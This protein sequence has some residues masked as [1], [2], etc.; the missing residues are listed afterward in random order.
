MRFRNILSAVRVYVEPDEDEVFGDASPGFA[1]KAAPLLVNDV[2]RLLTSVSTIFEYRHIVAHE[3]N[4]SIISVQKLGEYIECAKVFTEA[5]YELVDQI[6]NPGVSRTGYY[7]S[8]QEL[9]KAG[10]IRLE[11]QI[12][13]DE[14]ASRL[15]SAKEERPEAIGLFEECCKT[16]DLYENAE[17][18]F[19]LGLH[20]LFT[21]NAMRNIEANVAT[22]LWRHR[23]AYL[24]EV[25]EDVKFYLD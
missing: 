8:V 7:G 17:A 20:G 18:A 16:F 11:A 1:Q 25:A 24:S 23:H 4:F 10:A 2:S 21:G 5:L 13:Q 22:Q 6:L 19:R 15:R 12:I 3:A 9:T 14:I